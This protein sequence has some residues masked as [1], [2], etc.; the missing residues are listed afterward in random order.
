MSRFGKTAAESVDSRNQSGRYSI[1]IAAFTCRK[2][3][4]RSEC[5]RGFLCCQTCSGKVQ[6]RIRRIRHAERGITRRVLHG[7]IEHVGLVCSVAHGLVDKLHSLI[8]FRKF[9]H[10]NTAD[11]NE[12]DGQLLREVC[13][14]F[15]NL[16]ADILNLLSCRL[17]L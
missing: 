9:R 8:D 17:H 6:C 2:I 16:A 15:S 10:G 11:R 13:A 14:D 4:G 1:Q 12:R 7:L 3:H 5:R